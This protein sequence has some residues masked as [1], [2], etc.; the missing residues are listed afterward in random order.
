MQKATV[1][2]V[3]S[4]SGTAYKVLRYTN[5]DVLAY[6]D[7]L[8]ITPEEKTQLAKAAGISEY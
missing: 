1:D 4:Q 7:N 2:K 6:I 8:D 3:D 5:D